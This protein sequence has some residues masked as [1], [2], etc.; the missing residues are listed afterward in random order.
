LNKNTV[1]ACVVI[2]FC[3]RMWSFLSGSSL[4]SLFESVLT[5]EM[6]LFRGGRCLLAGL[7]PPHL[8]A[9]PTSEPGF[10]TWWSFF[11]LCLVS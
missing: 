5:L 4:S 9:C 1:H 8:C 2:Y 3:D 7:P 11:F 6:Q 10:P